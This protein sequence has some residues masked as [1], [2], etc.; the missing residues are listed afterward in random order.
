MQEPIKVRSTFGDY[1]VSWVDS[2]DPGFDLYIVD[3]NLKMK[4][5]NLSPNSIVWIDASENNKSYDHCAKIFEQLIARKLSKNTQVAVIGGGIIQDIAS[6]VSCLY[7]RGLTW[8]FYPSTLLAAVDSCIGSKISIN[9]NTTKNI[10]GTYYPPKAV[11][12]HD[13]FFKS[14]P[15]IQK[16]S[17]TAE[18]LKVFLLRNNQ[19]G[20]S[21]LKEL[22]TADN[23][24]ANDTANLNDLI[25][26][27]L[28]DKK[29]FIELDEFDAGARRLMN[30][31]HSFGHAI[32]A[33][34]RF[35]IPHGIA[36]AIGIILCHM[37]SAKILNKSFCDREKQAVFLAEL[38]IKKAIDAGLSVERLDGTGVFN[39]LKNDKKNSGNKFGLILFDDD[40]YLAEVE[41]NDTTLSIVN[42]CVEE[43]KCGFV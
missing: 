41:Q 19:R 43:F 14:L 28:E 5:N 23:L 31:G 17:G 10:I 21:K 11:Y 2:I 9:F 22:L 6:F 40:Y 35:E 4:V 27:A 37:T 25:F 18:A 33:D 38:I 20:L 42:S 32:E 30:L 7:K 15:T 8:Y 29:Y 24:D 3:A 16:L 39:Q 13:Q 36:V 34:T 26:L 1:T 12:I